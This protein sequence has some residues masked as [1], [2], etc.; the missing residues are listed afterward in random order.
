MS[1]AARHAD[2]RIA[3]VEQAAVQKGNFAVELTV[4][5]VVVAAVVAQGFVKERFQNVIEE[6]LIPAV[7][8]AFQPNTPRV[9]R[10]N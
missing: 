7:L 6:I 9:V 4:I 2:Y 10:N 8:L 3:G 5:V 1:Q